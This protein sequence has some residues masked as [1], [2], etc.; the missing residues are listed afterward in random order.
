MIHLHVLEKLLCFW[1]IR[2]LDLS[3]VDKI[4]LGGR[5]AMDLESLVVEGE[6]LFAARYV[7]D[8]DGACIVGSKVRLWL[9]DY[10]RMGR[11]TIFVGLVIVQRRLN[12]VWGNDN[13]FLS[14]L[15]LLCR[16]RR[17]G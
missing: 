7:V 4:L 17:R 8:C 13:L 2:G 10:G 11:G 14:G 9:A 1:I 3:V 15:R 16:C 12:V 6:F 5:L